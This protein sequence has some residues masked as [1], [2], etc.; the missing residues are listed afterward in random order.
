MSIKVTLNAK[1]V[2]TDQDNRTY[3]ALTDPK[4]VEDLYINVQRKFWSTR[5]N[6]KD[7][8]EIIEQ[9]SED[10]MSSRALAMS[11]L[12]QERVEKI[13][14][15]GLSKISILELGCANGITLRHLSKTADNL[16]VHYV[17]LELTPFLIDDLKKNFPD[18]HAYVGGAEELLSMTEAELGSKSFDVFIV[19]FVLSQIPPVVV[20]KVLDHVSRYCDTVIIRDYLINLNGE[21]NSEHP[22][23]FKHFPEARH[24]AF[25]HPYR[26]LLHNAGFYIERIIYYHGKRQGPAA[27]KEG[28]LCAKNMT[29]SPFAITPESD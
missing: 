3:Y 28:A 6:T 7:Y 29:L 13:R 17:G 5:N 2:F 21:L 10:Y 8:D 24:F 19:S 23:M 16:D 9:Q 15:E 11:H 22:V 4:Q 18:A 25:A 27:P 12:I 26:S 14:S 1:S 20:S